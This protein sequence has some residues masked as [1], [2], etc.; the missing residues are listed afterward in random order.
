MVFT[1][2]HLD[3]ERRYFNPFRV[4]KLVPLCSRKY[5]GEVES[6]CFFNNCY[7]DC[8]YTLFVVNRQL[9][10]QGQ[11]FQFSSPRS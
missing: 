6:E 11:R 10:C 1:K 2:C 4:G 3:R 5:L 9:L 7:I 8:P